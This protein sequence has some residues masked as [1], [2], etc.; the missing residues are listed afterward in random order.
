VYVGLRQLE[1]TREGQITDRFLRAVE[2]LGS[3][4][5]DV[6]FGGIYAL[7]RIAKDSPSDRAAITEVLSAF[8]R[9]CLPGSEARDDYIL[10]L[11]FRAPDAQAA[12][13]VLCR[14]PLSDAR[15]APGARRLDLSR[16]DLRR[17]DLHRANLLSANLWAARLE[18]AD[19]REANLRGAMLESA[20]FGTFQARNPAY[21]RGTDLT[22]AD[23][24]GAS[25]NHSVDFDIAV[26]DGA[27]GLA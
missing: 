4:K 7:E 22:G 16:T 21:Q 10:P 24:T 14:S 5:P 19:L 3:D 18:G 9:R 11:P 17:A 20:N 6:R 8:V 27:I 23:L 2:Q 12:L 1:L 25:L 26:K 13:T 15:I